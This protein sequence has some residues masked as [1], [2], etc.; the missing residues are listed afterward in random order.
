MIKALNYFLY[1]LFS[2]IL[3]FLFF[4]NF[5]DYNQNIDFI[6]IISN[7]ENKDEKLKELFTI[8]K[9]NNLNYILL[10]YLFIIILIL[11]YKRII[12]FYFQS[13]YEI[14]LLNIKT[15]FNLQK[16]FYY[17]FILIL[18]PS[19]FLKFFFIFY[20]PGTYDE[21]FTTINFTSKGFF[22]SIAYYPAPN[23]HVFFS[24]IASLF[25]YLP[26]DNLLINRFLNIII[27]LFFLLILFI[28]IFKTFNLRAA[29]ILCFFTSSLYPV[30]S[31]GYLSRGY[32]LIILFSYISFYLTYK[33]YL[34]SNNKKNIYLAVIS[35]MGFCGI[36]T[37]PSYLYF[38]LIIYFSLFIIFLIKNEYKNIFELF[39]HSLLIA[40]VL[41]IFYSPILFL[42]GFDSIFGNR[43]VDS[44]ETIELFEFIYFYFITLP[45]YLFVNHI[46]FYICISSFIFLSLFKIIYLKHYLLFL[47]TF[48]FP[49][50]IIII[51]NILP[52]ER[53]FVFMIPS[54][55]FLIALNFSKIKF[56]ILNNILSLLFI[57]LTLFS[58][59]D[60]F[61]RAEQH[62]SIGKVG[63]I[64]SKY[65]LNTNVKSIYLKHGLLDAFLIYYGNNKLNI[66][67]SYEN[68]ESIQNKNNYDLVVLD[69][70]KTFQQLDHKKTFIM[71]INRTNYNIYVYKNNNYE[72]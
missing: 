38:F 32:G 25:N 21:I 56:T 52:P 57:L 2:F 69:Y 31:Y 11:I 35:F 15:F 45:D 10:I 46:I 51:H 50:I 16:K 53:I 27:S 19:T 62:H 18:L 67:Y 37:N 26:F 14:L 7:T 43:F 58:F 42:S 49:F 3:I 59:Y 47:I 9:L 71:D 12:F 23:N 61:L 44:N 5:F 30:I 48:I 65:I 8:N 64:A 70:K 41:L 60:S 20:M 22:T 36:A 6:S 68:Y 63:N 34:S 13:F 72:E 33:I 40:I 39:L 17:I 55:I 24:I 66:N 28:S 29:I 1:I 54:F 4:I